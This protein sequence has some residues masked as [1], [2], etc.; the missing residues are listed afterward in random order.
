MDP[1]SHRRA[2]IATGSNARAIR[3]PGGADGRTGETGRAR[4]GDGPR[5]GP[6]TP[7]SFT[8]ISSVA[9][10]GRRSRRST[11]LAGD[12]R[13]CRA[14][15]AP[16]TYARGS[17]LSR[18]G[19]VGSARSVVGA[20]TAGAPPSTAAIKVLGGAGGRAATTPGR[21]PRA[22][23]GRDPAPGDAVGLAPRIASGAGDVPRARSGASAP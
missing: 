2:P 17:P 22:G 9:V 12:L 8:P 3:A 19:V 7:N 1:G 20:S 4:T 6:P 5:G 18:L 21:G 23:G 13:V 15:R 11:T 10:R 14:R 16:G